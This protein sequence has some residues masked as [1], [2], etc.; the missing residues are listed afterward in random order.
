MPGLHERTCFLDIGEGLLYLFLFFGWCWDCV[1]E[2][3]KI[4]MSQ[5]RQEIS[6]LI[7]VNMT[8]DLFC[9]EFRCRETPEGLQIAP[10]NLRKKEIKPLDISLFKE[11]RASNPSICFLARM[12]GGSSNTIERFLPWLLLYHHTRPRTISKIPIRYPPHG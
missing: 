2:F 8:L 1:G 9:G 5:Q 6:I 7:V 3:D 4:G 10:Q 11:S 12:W